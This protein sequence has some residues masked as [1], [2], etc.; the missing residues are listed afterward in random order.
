MDTT[1][2][3]HDELNKFIYYQDLQTIDKT[4]VLYHSNNAFI[5]LGKSGV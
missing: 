3:N 2:F 1:G 4:D 5:N